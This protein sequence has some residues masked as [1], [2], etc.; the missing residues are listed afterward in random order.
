[1]RS[2]PG[3]KD[4]VDRA[5]ARQDEW[6]ATEVETADKEGND[7]QDE[8][9]VENKGDDGRQQDQ[10]VPGDE[11]ATASSKEDDDAQM[12]GPSGENSGNDVEQEQDVDGGLRAE[13]KQAEAQDVSPRTRRKEKSKATS[14]DKGSS[15]SD[16]HAGRPS[17]SKHVKIQTPERPAAIK[18]KDG[19]RESEGRDNRPRREDDD[20]QMD[21]DDDED[22]SEQGS[23][24]MDSDGNLID[25]DTTSQ[26]ADTNDMMSGLDDIDRR[27]IRCALFGVDVTELYSPERVTKL[28][29]RFG[30]IPG[31]ALDLQTGWGFTR[32]DRKVQVLRLVRRE[33]PTIV[34]GSPPCTMM[35]MLQER[36]KAVQGK[37]ATL[38]QEFD[39]KFAEAVEH[40]KFCCV[41]YR[42]Q[43]RC[44]RYWLHEHPLSARSWDIDEMVK[45]CADPRVTVV[46]A[47]QCQYGLVAPID[48]TA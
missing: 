5:D 43:M 36:N 17:S 34:V 38:M 7:R 10:E 35:S 46:Q 12:N 9:A 27:N 48:K 19:C 29:T 40:V 37:D 14:L 30:L 6:I 42:L 23:T 20:T 28:C 1:M 3:D 15:P 45:L 39:R 16:V 31:S 4:R 18:R 11:E 22:S 13:Q 32:M 47:H 8:K 41:V 44:G 33:M 24:D 26:Q 2:D 21:N 25:K